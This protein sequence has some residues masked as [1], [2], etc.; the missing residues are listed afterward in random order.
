MICK[1]DLLEK[2]FCVFPDLG[3]GDFRNFGFQ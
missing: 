2:L 1:S 3:K